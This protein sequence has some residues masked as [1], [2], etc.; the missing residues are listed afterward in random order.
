MLTPALAL[1]QIGILLHLGHG[2]C[3]QAT[4]GAGSSLVLNIILFN[5][6]HAIYVVVA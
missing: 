1:T 6:C 5:R 3:S 4:E 2:L